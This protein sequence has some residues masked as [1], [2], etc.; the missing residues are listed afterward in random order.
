MTVVSPT[1]NKVTSRSQIQ[2]FLSP[3]PGFDR[4]SSAAYLQ[5]A[6][7]RATHVS[8]LLSIPLTHD[9]LP[10]MIQSQEGTA[11]C[12][13]CGTK[14]MTDW[15]HPFII[16]NENHL[17]WHDCLDTETISFV[18]PTSI[19]PSL[20]IISSFN[21]FLSTYIK[22]P[23]RSLTLTLHPGEIVLP[24]TPLSTANR[25]SLYMSSPCLLSIE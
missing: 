21:T 5:E 4:R 11:V 3:S 1:Y 15:G 25:T 6:L 14:M 20:C 10:E 23:L 9:R 7:Y 2:R 13:A 8:A 19:I 22:E 17:H 12:S 18:Y 16:G 24:F